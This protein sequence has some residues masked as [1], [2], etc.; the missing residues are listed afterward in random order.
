[1]RY[2]MHSEV[3]LKVYTPMFVCHFRTR[4]GDLLWLEDDLRE[5]K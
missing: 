2:L 5:R 1:M 4:K 3:F